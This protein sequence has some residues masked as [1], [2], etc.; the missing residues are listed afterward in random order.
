M[1]TLKENTMDGAKHTKANF[2]NWLKTATHQELLKEA[3][4]INTMLMQMRTGHDVG[5][6]PYPKKEAKMD[7]IRVLKYKYGLL[8]QK[9]LLG[10][11]Q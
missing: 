10:T 3:Q 4:K 6:P 7:N 1:K 8:N 9:I 2:K 11:K 5:L